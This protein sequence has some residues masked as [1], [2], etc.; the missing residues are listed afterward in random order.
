M[1]TLRSLE[2][3]KQTLL[4]RSS[5]SPFKVPTHDMFSW[6]LVEEPLILNYWYFLLCRTASTASLLSQSFPREVK[7]LCYSEFGTQNQVSLLLHSVKPPAESWPSDSLQTNRGLQVKA[8]SNWAIPGGSQG[9][10]SVRFFSILLEVHSYLIP[11]QYQ[12]CYFDITSV[13]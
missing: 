13:L 2:R 8:H 10:P 1:A 12:M 5:Q 4:S 6:V 3:I 11:R 9:R 7:W